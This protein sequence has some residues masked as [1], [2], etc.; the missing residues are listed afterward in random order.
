MDIESRTMSDRLG[1]I[2][3]ISARQD[4]AIEGLTQEVNR[5]AQAVESI[6]MRVSS[7]ARTNWPVLLSAG[8]LILG[9]FAAIFGALGSGYVRDL[10]RMQDTIQSVHRAASE[11][12]MLPGHAPTILLTNGNRDLLERSRDELDSLSK[13]FHSHTRTPAHQ[14]AGAEISGLKLELSTLSQARD[15]LIRQTIEQAG[16]IEALERIVFKDR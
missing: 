16:R 10:D 1:A 13:E 8:G 12:V 11:H 4:A 5:M 6:A 2:E 9:I 3:K 14:V 7:D 15:G